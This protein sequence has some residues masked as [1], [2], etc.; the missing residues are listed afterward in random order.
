MMHGQKNIKFKI[1]FVLPYFSQRW[2]HLF[3]WDILFLSLFISHVQC[4]LFFIITAT[5][6]HNLRDTHFSRCTY[7]R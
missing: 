3:T 2:Q 1:V 7:L 6:E 4:S 5:T